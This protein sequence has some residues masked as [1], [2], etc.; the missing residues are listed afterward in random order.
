MGAEQNDEYREANFWVYF[1]IFWVYSLGGSIVEHVAYFLGNKRKAITNPILTGFPIY[2]LGAYFVIYINRAMKQAMDPEGD[3][4]DKQPNPVIEF[5]LYAFALTA[6]EYATGILLKAGKTSYV[7][8]GFI[9]G[10]DYSKDAYN[11]DGIV[12]LQNFIAFGVF[13]LLVTRIHPHLVKQVNKIFVCTD[14][15]Q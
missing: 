6:I 9:H 12:K 5:L 1:I 13:G 4:P 15:S 3:D 11:L 7:E 14:A 8:C 10:W 2:G